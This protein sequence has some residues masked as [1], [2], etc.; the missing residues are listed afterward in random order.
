MKKVDVAGASRKAPRPRFSE[1]IR[2]RRASAR[3]ASCGCPECVRYGPV[4]FGFRPCEEAFD[5]G[6][7]CEATH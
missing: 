2:E 7:P 5:A 6:R 4:G 3:P 1:R